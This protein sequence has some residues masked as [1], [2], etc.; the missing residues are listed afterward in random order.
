[1]SGA[2]SD[3]DVPAST[4]LNSDAV[5]RAPMPSEAPVERELS[6][7][8]RIMAAAVARRER[9][10]EGEVK[11]WDDN[12]T[13][14]LESQIAEQAANRKPTGDEREED[15][16]YSGPYAEPDVEGSAGSAAPVEQS[17]RA[18]PVAPSP[19]AEP[20]AA[21]SV[22]QTTTFPIELDGQIIHVTQEQ[23][24]HLARMGAIANQALYQYNQQPREQA[25]A[26]HRE[27]EQP[28]PATVDDGRINETV[29]AIQYGDP[30]TAATALKGLISDVVRTV[31]AAPTFDPNAIVNTAVQE[32]MRRQ[33][34][35]HDTTVVQQE[36]ADVLSDPIRADAAARQ[37]AMI[38]QQNIALG[39]QVSDLE[40]YREAGNRVRQA[41]GGHQP[42]QGQAPAQAGTPAPQAPNLIVRRSVADIEGRKR[43]APQRTAAVI[44]RR[45]AAPEVP[46][47]PSG[48]DIVEQM[49]KQRHQSSMR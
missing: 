19:S 27:V 30:E 36:Y 8:D 20:P 22:A 2:R 17:E 38:R 16:V 33:Q 1:M 43:A 29:R 23:M 3:I 46:R 45:S 41:F 40:V 6:A 32:S 25:P 47:P 11:S 42:T 5:D 28:R 44:D 7:R 9:E 18:P 15:R 14:T 48:S 49:R 12:S 24:A 37:V 35:A 31:P 13:G 4:L 39:R 10:L 21:A 34:L 26:Q